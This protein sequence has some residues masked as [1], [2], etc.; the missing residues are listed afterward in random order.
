MG[1]CGSRGAEKDGDAREEWTA[2]GAGT[3][4]VLAAE[5]T[6]PGH[7]Q[8]QHLQRALTVN[9]KPDCL[10]RR[11]D[12]VKYPGRLM[13]GEAPQCLLGHFGQLV[14]LRL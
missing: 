4:V 7:G 3:A 6:Q 2:K 10:L 1:T 11:A 9:S 5:M 14:L 12:R 13:S 8:V